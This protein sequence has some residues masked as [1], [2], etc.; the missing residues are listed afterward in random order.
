MEQYFDPR[1]SNDEMRRVCPVAMKQ[2][3]RFEPETVREYLL[4]RGFKPENVICYCYRPFD[5]RWLYW[6][7]ETKLLDEKR[8]ESFPHVFAGNVWLAAVQQNRKSFDP[9]LVAHTMCSLHVIERGANMFPL[10][11]S[12]EKPQ[13]VLGGNQEQNLSCANVSQE[14]VS[15]T[16]RLN[17]SVPDIFWHTVA[18]LHAPSYREHNAAALRQDW[19][20]IPLPDSKEALLASAA[21]GR[22]IAA[23]LDTETP[24]DVAAGLSRHVPDGGVK[25]P[26]QQIATFTLPHGIT[27]DET[28]HFAVTAGWGHAGQGGVTMPGKGKVIERDYTPAERNAGFQPAPE[29]CRQDAGATSTGRQDAGA[30]LGD[31]TCDIYLND[32]AYWSNIPQRV[33]EY[34]IGGYQVMKKWL[35]Y[36]E[37][38]LLGRPLTKDE[39][40][41]VQEMARRIAAILLL[42]PALDENYRKVKE[43]TYPWP[44][45]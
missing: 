1:L 13:R 14:A 10:Y 23:L 15:Y 28:K 33:W 24:F 45:E 2:G 9:P 32:V 42:E 20:R 22:Q 29:Q 16:E 5:S 3:S 40:R 4:R 25:P 12:D 39:V 26:L 37:E 27:L 8:S 18:V 36:R 34:T 35:S 31:R 43:H 11:L 44:H 7:P 38:R 30:T 17:A 41:Y 6:E 21:L 19:P